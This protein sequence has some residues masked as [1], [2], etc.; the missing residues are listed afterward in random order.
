MRGKSLTVLGKLYYLIRW[1]SIH[2]NV[3]LEALAA[4]ASESQPGK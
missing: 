3:L 4:S 1:F 2:Y